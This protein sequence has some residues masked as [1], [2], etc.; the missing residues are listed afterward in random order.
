VW[1]IKINAER[2]ENSDGPGHDRDTFSSLLNFRK[3]DTQE[4]R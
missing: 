4:P 2:K 3:A 1:E